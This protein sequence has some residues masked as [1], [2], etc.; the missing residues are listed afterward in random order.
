MSVEEL[1]ERLRG[2]ER[3]WQERWEKS[4]IF[5]ADPDKSLKKFYLTVAYPYPNSP[6]HIGHGRTYGLTDA[7][8]RF[9]RMQGYNVLFPMAFHYT[10]TPILAMAKRLREGDPE[11]I[12]SFLRIY[13]IPEEK[14]KELEDPLKMARYFHEEIKAGMKLMGYSI[15][16]RREFT[17]I[18]PAYNK[19]ITWQF[20]KLQ[21]RGYL[22]KGKHPVGWCPRCDNAV[23]QHDTRGDVEPEITEVTLIKFEG[24]SLIIPTATYRPETVFGVTNIWINPEVEYRIVEVNGE[25]WVLS[26][27]AVVKLKFQGFDVKEVGRVKGEELIGRYFRNP[28]TGKDVPVLPAKFVKPDYGTGIVMSVPGHAPYDFLALRD[29]KSDLETLRRYGI[30]DISGLEPI[31]IIEV[32]GFSD[33]PAKDAVESLGVKDQL[34]VKAEEATQLIYS[35]EYHTGR[36]KANTSY[37]GMPVKEAKE[38][39]KEDLIMSGK[40]HKFYEIANSP[41]YCRCGAKVVVKIVED[42]W[43]IDYSNPEWKKLAHEALREMRIIPK[44][45]RREFEDA[46]DW[47]RE[48]AC[49]RK[50]GLGT[51]LPFDPNWIIES[52]SD[53]TIYMAFY[54]ISKYINSGILD[55]SKLDEEVFD[56]IFLG[57]GNEKD[58]S[59]RKGIDEDVLRRVREEFLYWYPLDSRHS[60]RDLVWNHLTFFIFNHVAIFPRDLWPRQIVVNGSVTMEGKKMSKSLGNIIPIRRAVE[61]FGADPIRLSVMGSAEL[62]SDADFSPI[63]ASS[64][65]KRLF[66]ILDLASKF[67]SFDEELIVEDLWDMWLVTMLKLHVK[68]ITDAMEECRAREAI[69]HSV[70]L[71]L[72]EVEEYLEAKGEA[73]GRLMKYILNV[74]ARL[75]APFAP[76]VAEEIWETI[77]EEG[78]VSLAPWPSHE[79]IPEYREADISYK[80]LSN[81]IEDVKSI[82]SSGI[83]GSNLYIYVASPWKYELFRRIEELKPKIGLDPRRLIPELMKNPAFRERG[84]YVPEIVK[85]LSSGGWPWLP[86][87]DKELSALETAKNYLERKLGMKIR[88]DLEENPSYDPKKRA[89]RALPGRPAIYIE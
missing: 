77:G 45:L 18:D 81:I 19:F 30:E 55:A 37:P 70:Y 83:S 33:L 36:M 38:R 89:S 2:I 29:L 43:F 21:E 28:A 66:R 7:Y 53:S 42:Q 15:D 74:W 52:L 68:E 46:I 20:M 65:L 82:S 32:E 4:R 41:V 64:T 84:S 31:S 47:M 50:S 1:V 69:H 56:Y 88:V 58:L 85:Q 5:E 26:E 78:F 35:K 3:K 13:G 73:N 72:N 57:K 9:K 44:E 67:S 87:R 75:L 80:V 39:V 17:T 71:L 27:E 63:V 51:R 22:T 49:A 25:R 60:G 16:W 14:I 48:K 79:E 86:D 34:D 12:D 76:H 8:A 10:G 62:S 40:A 24:D 6:Q 54:T 11:I 61:L 23:G 59:S